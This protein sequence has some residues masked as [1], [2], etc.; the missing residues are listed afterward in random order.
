[1]RP[2][3]IFFVYSGLFVAVF[4][5][6][7]GLNLTYCSKSSLLLAFCFLFVYVTGIT[8][9]CT[10]LLSLLELF[11]GIICLIERMK[12][13]SV[14]TALLGGRILIKA[15]TSEPSSYNGTTRQ[16]AKLRDTTLLKG[17]L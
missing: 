10:S 17:S 8:E 2:I 5:H 14:S 16:L 3:F 6:L 1:M 13:G 4:P 9:I 12:E 15:G 11:Q 7:H